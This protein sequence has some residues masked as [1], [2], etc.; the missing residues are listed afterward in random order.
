MA[1]KKEGAQ[2]LLDTLES[3]RKLRSRLA[4]STGQGVVVSGLVW[5]FTGQ[6]QFAVA[7]VFVIGLLVQFAFERMSNS[8]EASRLQA[9]SD[10]GWKEESL[11]D[12]EYRT[13]IEKTLNG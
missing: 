5:Y 10:L 11:S 12:E 6:W 7:S 9:L 2:R 13:R 4:F 8:I 1:T 3:K